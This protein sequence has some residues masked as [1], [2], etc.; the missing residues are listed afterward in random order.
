MR[1]LPKCLLAAALAS[2]AALLLLDHDADASAPAKPQT[3]P[4]A[5]VSVEPAV[6]ASFAPRHWA[7]GSVISREDSRIAAE[8]GGRIVRIAEVGQHVRRGDA[9]AVLDDTA[10]SLRERQAA[11]DLARIQSQLDLATRQE[12]RYAQLAAQQNIARSQH[13][14]LQ[15]ERDVLAQERAS[16]D[17][18]L[19][20][21]RHQ[22]TQMAIRA[23]FPGVVVERLAQPGEYLTAGSAVARLVDTSDLEVRIRAPV[24]L[25]RHLSVGTRV[26]LR[27]A[28][29]ESA[30]P[31]TALVPVG[32]EASRQ[33][34]LRVGATS[35][36]LPVGTAVE[37]GLPSDTKRDVLA[38]PRDA[39]VLRREGSF[40]LR[41]DSA[42]KAERI[43]VQTG[44]NLDG[45]VEVSGN[46][47]AGDRLIVRGGERVEAGQ[48]VTIQPLSNA[49]AAR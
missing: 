41:V 45:L 7:P 40:V 38:V 48:A 13:D 36:R 27:V 10:L 19:A 32:D 5:I 18:T 9:L 39:V 35:L 44:A 49:V 28:G 11:A 26:L 4:P 37:A 17:A 30:H 33:L 16:A 1:L 47:R 25:A 29:Q 23:P 14:Q 2:P 21:I 31:I 20:Q 22:R 24:D 15:A 43:S 12:A 34:E 3:P 8:Q 46:L 42:N 6:T